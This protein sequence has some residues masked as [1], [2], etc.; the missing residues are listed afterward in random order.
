MNNFFFNNLVKLIFGKGKISRLS[1]EMP[2]AIID[3][4]IEK[5]EDFFRSVGQKIRLSEY[6]IGQDTIG[7]IVNK[8]KSVNWNI[9][10]NGMVSPSN[11]LEIIESRL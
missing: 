9:E 8:F 3:A 2:N 11:V 7:I 4:V 1:E 6:G 10:E 5:T